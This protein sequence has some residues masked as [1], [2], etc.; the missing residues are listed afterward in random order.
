MK[1]Q[2]P[3]ASRLPFP[4]SIESKEVDDEI[5]TRMGNQAAELRR[6][7]M[8]PSNVYKMKHG[9]QWQTMHSSNPDE[10]TELRSHSTETAVS[11]QRLIDHDVR[12]LPIF[13]AELTAKMHGLFVR[14]MIDMLDETTQRS[15]NVV[16]GKGMP[17]NESIEE[18]LTKIAFGV[19]R[20]GKPSA[21]SVFVPP[22]M[23]K[24]LAAIIETLGP[25]QKI[26]VAALERKNNDAIAEEARRISRYRIAR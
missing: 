18:I 4:Y 7:F 12:Q 25:E 15:G 19:D 23:V 17:L 22:G 1:T 20:Y 16:S 13:I 21:P 6:E 5:T 26:R 11:R 9:R 3:R 14:T 10:A 8:S 24:S 2:A